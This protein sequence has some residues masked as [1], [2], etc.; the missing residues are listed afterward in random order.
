[1][2]DKALTELFVTALES[3][4]T[5]ITLSRNM[6]TCSIQLSSK[7]NSPSTE[8]QW[9]ATHTD[10]RLAGLYGKNHWNPNEEQRVL[11]PCLTPTGQRATCR[12]EHVPTIS[13]CYR[14]TIEFLEIESGTPKQ[15]RRSP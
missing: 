3:G 14:A 15:S 12:Y 5:T 7:T 6:E 4:Q 8:L 13:G 9:D 11:F 2:T 1:M 10:Q